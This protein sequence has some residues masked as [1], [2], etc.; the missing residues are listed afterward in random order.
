MSWKIPKDKHKEMRIIKGNK[1]GNKL[2]RT[3]WMTWEDILTIWNILKKEK[4]V[5]KRTRQS[6]K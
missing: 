6:V 2:V 4:R 5:V 3:I 1:E